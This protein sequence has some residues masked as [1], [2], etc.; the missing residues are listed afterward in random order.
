MPMGVTIRP[1]HVDR[2]LAG[3]IARNTNPPTEKTAGYLTWGADEHLLGALA[4][5]WWLWCRGKPAAQ[6]RAS[7]HVL[8][9]TLVSAALPHLLKTIFDQERPDRLTIRGHL[10]GVPRS[11]KKMDAFPSGHA[12]HVGALASAASVL[13]ARSRNLAWA[14]GAALV[15]TR[16]VLLAHWASDVACGVAIGVGLE[17][18]MRHVTG[19]GRASPQEHSIGTR[20]PRSC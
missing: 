19:Y 16:V 4:I 11:G 2:A 10:H 3:V 12:I 17:R 7:D 9:T 18:L 1:T 6:R 13:P 15:A 8:A 20:H 5:G 14:T